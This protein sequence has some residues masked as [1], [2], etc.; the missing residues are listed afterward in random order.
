MSVSSSK[1]PSND[2]NVANQSVQGVSHLIVVQ[3]MAKLLTFVLNQLIIRYLSPSIIGATTYL[4]FICSTILFFSRE[5][6]RLSVQRVRNNSNNKDYVAQKVINFGVLAIALAFPIFCAIGYWQLNYSSVMDKLFL[7]PFYKPVIVLFVASV[8]LELLVEPIYCLYQFQLDFGKR[9]KFE[10]SAIFVKCI[11]SVL[12][13]LL[14][15][16]YFFGQNF[17]AAAICAFALAQFGYSMTLF[18]CYFTSFKFE[19]QNHEIKYS[20]VKLKDENAREFYFERDTLII[21]KG[22]FVQM[23]FKQFLTEGDKLLT[24]HLCTIEEQGMYAVMANYGSIIARL[25]FQPLEEST[26]LMFTK[27]LNDNSGSETEEKTKK[28]ESSKYTQTFNYLKLIS[29]FYFNLSLIILFA[30]VTSGPYL[31]KL[32]MGGRASNWENTDIFKLF[33]QYIVYLPF[34]AFNG[35]L[36]ALF[37][38]MATNSDLKNFSKF[39]T[40][41]TILVLLISFLLIDALN[42]RISGLILANIFN[43]SS[44][45]G[46][47]YFKISK[48]YSNEHVKISF[49]DIIR[50]SYPSI[51]ITSIIWIIQFFII[52]QNTTNFSQL[53][54]NA[55]FSFVLLILLM[56]VESENLK[57]PFE[58]VTG[59][60][61]KTKL[62]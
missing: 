56:I 30:G 49:V 29:I 10:G 1:H 52:G 24:S 11:V 7:S 36:E 15:R 19:F 32:L 40:L 5:S 22:F 39:M 21:V 8:I 44:R 58:R 34:L 33:P 6:I 41:I 4:E 50:Y 62:D 3:I 20:L 55:C 51:M 27:L 13:I 23:I 42:L 35:I 17:E 14:A 54:L 9:S 28:S 46:Y 25:L 45:I 38:S 37:S 47:C 18:A 59:K 26:R 53:I 61:L 43:M 16:Q 2:A 12:S 48:F 60:L 31:L 57:K